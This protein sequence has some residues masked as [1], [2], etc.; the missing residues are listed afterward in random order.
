MRTVVLITSLAMS[1]AGSVR[2]GLLPVVPQP[3]GWAPAESG[4]FHV[5]K[6]LGVSGGSLAAKELIADWRLVR[7][8]AAAVYAD[9]ETADVVFLRGEKES[10]ADE[11]YTL[12]ISTNRICVS[13]DSATGAYWATRTLL[14][15]FRSD[16]EIPCGTIVDRPKYRYRGFMLD[17]ARKPF[18]MDFLRYLAKTFAYYKMNV[19][20]VHLNDQGADVFVKG[21]ARFR[22]ECETCPE[23]TAKD[24]HYTKREFREFVRTAAGWGVTVIP[25]IDSPAHVGAFTR[26]RPD[27]ASKQYGTDHF[28]LSNPEVPAFME[29]LYEEYLGG[30]DPVFTGPYFHVGTD[31]YDKRESEAFRAYTDRMLRAVKRFGRVPCAW[32]ALSHAD[33]TTPVCHE[34]VVMDIW[35][36]SYYDP[37]KAIA[38]GYDIVSIPDD[39]H[40]I[41]PV[42]GYYPDYLDC[43]MLFEDWEPCMIAGVTLPANHPRLLGGKFALWNDMSGNGISEDDVFDR[44]FPAIQTLSQKMWSGTVAGQD[45][46][47]F[48]ALAERTHEA[49]GNNQADR[50]TGPGMTP[51]AADVAVGWSQKGGYTVSFDLRPT[52]T[53]Q[54]VRLFEDGFSTVSL[55]SG[56]IGFE[57]DGASF[58]WD[59]TLP[60]GIWSSLR[61]VGDSKGVEL[62]VDGESA[63][64]SAGKKGYSANWCG[65]GGERYFDAPRTLHFPLKPTG[66]AHAVVKNFCVRAG[67][68]HDQNVGLRKVEGRRIQ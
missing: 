6:T 9:A 14:Q 10:S 27:F 19:F 48:S 31:E 21:Y 38:A 35:H 32:G 37:L 67:K 57:R 20:H 62:F 52:E 49:P 46:D 59:S 40:Y 56:K 68:A 61:F 3:T 24:F 45:W 54:T 15:L 36:N 43:K 23:L 7:G 17:V 29:K 65:W 30:D 60:A 47:S 51:S 1:F 42:A 55:Q 53:N 16:V 50:L 4:T 58:F 22:L 12:V 34:G 66:P 11:G 39:T 63:G 13:S 64:V 2:A 44:V 28:D 8:D 26:A 33:G 25:E 5:P 41:V 18:S